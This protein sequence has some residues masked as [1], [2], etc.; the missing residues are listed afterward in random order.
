MYLKFKVYIYNYLISQ[1]LHNMVHISVHPLLF[2]EEHQSQRRTS[3]PW[4]SCVELL[5]ELGR[6]D[7][8]EVARVLL[9]STELLEHAPDDAPNG[10]IALR[11]EVMQIEQ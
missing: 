4:R 7:H 3:R 11:E 5:F 8:F 2:D 1:M 9:Q 6:G 10:G